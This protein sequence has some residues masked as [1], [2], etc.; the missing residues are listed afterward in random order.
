MNVIW[1]IWDFDFE[2]DFKIKGG[3]QGILF[4][5]FKRDMGI[6]KYP[7][8]SCNKVVDEN[9]FL[10]CFSTC[11]WFW[12]EARLPSSF[13]TS[14]GVRPQL[15]FVLRDVEGCEAPGISILFSYLHVSPCFPS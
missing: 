15:A 3:F 12:A 1:E 10:E 9:E 6:Y 11:V 14:R 13:G 5:N 4:L 8:S 7:Y 2:F